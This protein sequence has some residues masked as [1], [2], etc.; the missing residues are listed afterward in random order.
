MTDP[1]TAMRELAPTEV[2]A[3]YPPHADT[4]ASLLASRAQALPDAEAV[5]FQSRSWRYGM[6]QRAAEA[7]A[8]LLAARGVR[9]GD[10][11]AH[12]AANSD[13]AIVLFL[14]LARLGAVFVPLN[15]ALTDDELLYQLDHS[16]AVAVFTPEALVDRVS[17][18]QA[19]CRQRASILA[20]EALGSDAP[21]A[22]AALACILSELPADAPDAPP[23]PSPDTPA[24]VIYTSGTTGFPKGVVHSQRNVVWAAEVF[25][26]RLRLQPGER[27]LTV[28]PLF[29]VNA[30]FY[31]FAGALACGG[32]FITA[33]RF[34]ASTFW[35]TAADTG[36][37]QLNILAA[38][39]GILGLRPRTEFNP[40]HRIRKIYGGP[41]SAAMFKLFQ[42]EFGV[43]LLI[44][45]YGMSEIPAA[46]SNPYDGP[47][48]LG[49]IGTAGRH[50]RVDA[51]R[52]RL[53]VVDD[54]GLDVRA[55]EVGELLV[56]TPMMFIGYLNDPAQTAAA[57]R[58]DWFLTGDLVR[59]DAD[60]YL[61]FVAR[62]KD[63]IRKRGENISGAELDMLLGQHPDVAEAATIAVPSS[64]GDD[65]ILAVLVP[66]AGSAPT[67]EAVLEWCR[68]HMAAIKVP[69][70]LVFAPSLPKTPT[71][72]VAKHLLKK[73]AELISRARDMDAAPAA[74]GR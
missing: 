23:L 68:G 61:Y 37:T 3:L 12:I 7:G 43:P 45:G 31:S 17:A 64:L 67:H 41:I 60:G 72:R 28:F 65:D 35:Q 29:H 22:G 21:D 16:G 26:A 56:Q 70:Y 13:A 27:L 59:A 44:E 9:P 5:L 50:P 58:D 62:K 55:G 73:D 57:F 38:L 47:H 54:D 49:S 18:V 34:S 4:L 14:S 40:V 33:A 20:L 53:R 74:E 1:T 30:L 15:P 42:Q 66:R 10:P 63:I 24:V 52:V 32:T 51:A 69:R 46:C 71:Q 19:R 8:R 11:V 25:V 48:K 36:A 39:G 2:F 6:L